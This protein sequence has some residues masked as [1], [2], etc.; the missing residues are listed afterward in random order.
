MPK[1]AVFVVNKYPDVQHACF[2]AKE[3]LS[4]HVESALFFG[5]TADHCGH[6][7][8]DFFRFE[9]DLN[10]SYYGRA[11]LLFGFR[12]Y[13]GSWLKMYRA[14]TYIEKSW[15]GARLRRNFQSI[16]E[17]ADFIFVDYTVGSIVAR[18]P[19]VS[20]I[21]QVLRSNKKR[22][23]VVPHAVQMFRES[24]SF[25]KP[26]AE[27]FKN[28][29]SNWD[30]VVHSD[31]Q[32]LN[33]D[34]INLKWTLVRSEWLNNFLQWSQQLPPRSLSGPLK[35]CLALPGIPRDESFDE[36]FVDF[37]MDLG[38]EVDVVGHPR[39]NGSYEQKS[40][41]FSENK[42]IL[43]LM[44]SDVL[45]CGVSAFQLYAYVLGIPVLVAK[46]LMFPHDWFWCESQIAKP[47]VL[48]R[49]QLADYL[50]RMDMLRRQA[51][52][53]VKQVSTLNAMRPSIGEALCRESDV[54]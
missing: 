32:R 6:L 14:G 38:F 15:L 29:P 17:H 31:A 48:D 41:R 53:R 52:E 43:E 39:M 5:V 44:S 3:L 36:S 8:D 19:D 10:G 28:L 50:G 21:S 45:I 26:I 34:S 22:V 4:G 51:L 18:F 12:K 25:Y 46:E 30:F 7:V 37:V 35:I 13:A 24:P 11:R 20:F 23:I 9:N 33:L 47:P 54:C 42:S 2:F 1:N 27:S 40:V 16:I 49:N